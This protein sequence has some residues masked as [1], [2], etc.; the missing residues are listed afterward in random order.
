MGDGF[1]KDDFLKGIDEHFERVLEGEDGGTSALGRDAGAGGGN[2]F[3]PADHDW[4][5]SERGE[6]DSVSD[7]IL[8]HI[9]NLSSEEQVKVLEFIRKL[10][11]RY[12]T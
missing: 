4:S 7:E 11:N 12:P 6:V 5:G 8:S 3:P 2:G 10:R 9:Q 1:P